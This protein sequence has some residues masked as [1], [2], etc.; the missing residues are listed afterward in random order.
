MIRTLRTAIAPSRSY[1]PHHPERDD[2][3]PLPEY[4]EPPKIHRSAQRVNYA[5]G[6]VANG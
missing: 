3:R 2:A 5:N 6:L 1:H 4:L